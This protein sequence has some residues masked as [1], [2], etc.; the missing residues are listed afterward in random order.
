MTAKQV[1]LINILLPNTETMARTMGILIIII[2]QT[3]RTAATDILGR[4]VYGT[5]LQMSKKGLQ[6]QN[7][8][9]DG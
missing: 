3:V 8:T 6:R 2:L 5:N 9:R 7:V 1:A 4:T